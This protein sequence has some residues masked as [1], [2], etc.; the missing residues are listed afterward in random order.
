MGVECITRHLTPTLAIMRIAGTTQSNDFMTPKD[1][2]NWTKKASALA[3][4][5]L[6]L[7]SV[8]YKELS[9]RLQKIDISISESAISN[10]LNSGT[11]ST[12]FLFQ[13]MTV[14]GKKHLTIP[15]FTEGKER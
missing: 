3:K 6:A 13:I 12:T 5:M 4:S 9:I 15:D 14:L 11:F 8:S 1:D 10:R 7:E 2:I